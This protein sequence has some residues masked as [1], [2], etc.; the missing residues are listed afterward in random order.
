MPKIVVEMPENRLFAT[1][2][3]VG[4]GDLNYGNHLS[5]DAVLRLCHEVRMRWLAAAGWSELDAGG[6]G[7]I[8]A[9]AAVQYLAQAHYGDGLRVE[10]GA[11]E[12]GRSGFA[13][14]YHIIREA[15]ARSIARVR[16]GMV[17]FDY[18]RQAVCRLPG[19]LKHT[20]EAV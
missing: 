17:C 6:A 2:L 1:Y 16:T 7:L 14:L 4:V 5:N 12:I 10:M 20:L 19:A 11:A 18:A 15:D 8:M 9:D 13:L 3:A